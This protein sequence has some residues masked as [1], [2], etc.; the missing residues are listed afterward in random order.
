M[1]SGLAT[2]ASRRPA[3]PT[4]YA[5]PDHITGNFELRRV[6]TRAGKDMDGRRF[7]F[8]E[9]YW[10]HLMLGN[11]LGDVLGAL[12]A[13]F[14]RRPRTVPETLRGVWAT[15]VVCLSLV[16]LLLLTGVL[17]EAWR[18]AWLPDW[19]WTIGAA[20]SIALGVFA[21][22]WLAPVAGD[23]ARY[24]RPDPANVAARQKIR[25]A[26]VELLE[27]LTAS[28]DYDRIILVG[29]SLGTVIG[30]DVLNHAFSRLRRE[31]LASAHADP[32]LMQAL[33]A[34]EE[35]AAALSDAAQQDDQGKRRTAYRAAQR[36]YANLVARSGD[37]PWLVTDFVTL[38]SPLSKADVLLAATADAFQHLLDRREAPTCPP[39]LEQA[40]PPR[41]SYPPREA[42][43]IPH[44]AA[45]FAPVVWTNIYYPH[46][47]VLSG[48]VI[49]GPIAPL[50]GRAIR[51]VEVPIG[52][53]GFRHLSYWRDPVAID[54]L[55]RAVNLRQADEAAL[56]EQPDATVGKAPATPLAPT[57]PGA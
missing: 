23:A 43:R 33:A 42:Q 54:A 11:S 15:G 6:T 12:Q 48:D 56:W 14:M 30:Y 2:T 49:S 18:P 9:F 19:I 25:E 7:D 21:R 17:P 26:G 5:K 20:A 50:L 1:R 53:P 44:H 10:A 3:H 57:A 8:F 22:R 40:A 35:A 29:H 55:R 38:G 28:G 4:S 41:F 37:M 51:D 24:L 36:A 31:Q 47:F 46:R 27:K 16:G 32:A 45:V 13:L 52:N 34:L 39:R